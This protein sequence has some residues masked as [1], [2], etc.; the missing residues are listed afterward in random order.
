MPA[1]DLDIGGRSYKI[2]CEEGQEA[3]LAV[4]ARGIDEHVTALKGRF[5]EIGDT[6]LTIMAALL[7]AD[8]LHEM[9]ARATG[10]ERKLADSEARL[11]RA[12]ADLRTCEESAVEA[13]T[14]AAERVERLAASLGLHAA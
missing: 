2:S 9:R 14:L 6:R 4:L 7:V 13:V 3:H 1:L 8:E 11:E 10:L 5:G 12:M